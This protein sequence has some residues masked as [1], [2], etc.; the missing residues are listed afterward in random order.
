MARFKKKKHVP[1][2]FE[3]IGITS[4]TSANIYESML[5]SPAWQDLSKG[6]QNLY[7]YC[8]SQ[9]YSEKSN[10]LELKNSNPEV[11]TMNRHKWLEK[12]NIYNK[13]NANQFYKD[14]EALILHGFVK[15]ILIGAKARVKNIYQYSNKWQLWGTKEFEITRDEMTLRMINKYK[16]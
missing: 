6:Q 4:D 7:V 14:M 9:Y 16:K 11:F 15:C 13:G 1:K 8:K 5:L 10:K 3:S 12:Y 2:P